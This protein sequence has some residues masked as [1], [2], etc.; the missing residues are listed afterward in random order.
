[1]QAFYTPETSAREA[2]LSPRKAA[3]CFID[4]QNYNCSKEGAIYRALSAQEQEV[5]LLQEWVVCLGSYGAAA[6]CVCLRGQTADA[7]DWI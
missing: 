5:S 2:A 1:M 6:Y 7:C 3:I 4:T